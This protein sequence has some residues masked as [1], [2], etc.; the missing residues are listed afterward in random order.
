MRVSV[1]GAG[2]GGL[3]LAQGLHRAGIDVTVHDRD[4]HIAATGGYRLALDGPACA[5][6]RRHLGPEHYQALLGSS[7]PPEAFSTSSAMR[8]CVTSPRCSR[9]PRRSLSPPERPLRRR[10]AAHPRGC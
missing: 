7:A 4:P 3:A 6:L 9:R 8:S 1:I 5:V 10:P 2:I